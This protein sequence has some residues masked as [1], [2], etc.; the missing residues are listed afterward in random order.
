MLCA[1]VLSIGAC[2]NHNTSITE[3]ENTN[4]TIVKSNDSIKTYRIK[5]GKMLFDMNCSACHIPNSNGVAPPFQ[6]L[7]NTQSIDWITAF[8]QNNIT[9]REKGDIRA[10]YIY[11]KWAL[12]SMNTH[13]NLSKEDIIAILDYV[14]SFPYDEKNYEFRNISKED[15]IKFNQTR[16]TNY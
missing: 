5:S 15:M 6:R 3:E 14:D 13:E 4:D 11:N 10:I 12:M 2:N 1:L 16:E 8:V 9:L 7:R